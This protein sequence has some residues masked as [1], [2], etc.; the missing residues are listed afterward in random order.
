M[1]TTKRFSNRVANYVNYDGLKGRLL[2]SSYVPPEDHP[3]STRMLEA[4]KQIFTQYEENGTVR[5]LYDTK[6]HHE[7]LP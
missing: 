6:V 1:K 5:F 4:L 2:S 3:A 7:T